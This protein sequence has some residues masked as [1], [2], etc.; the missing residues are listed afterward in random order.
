M[1]LSLGQIKATHTKHQRSDADSLKTPKCIEIMTAIAAC[2]KPVHSEIVPGKTTHLHRDSLHYAIERQ[3]RHLEERLTLSRST[4][5]GF[6]ASSFRI[7][8]SFDLKCL[9]PIVS[10][11]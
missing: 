3:V 7:A 5:S 9:L 11:C 8:D 6:K 1:L 4:A 10:S 2:S